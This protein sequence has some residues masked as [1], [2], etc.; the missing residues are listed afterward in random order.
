MERTLDD[1]AVRRICIPEAFLAADACLG[2]LQNVAEGLVV[3]P[4]VIRRR[5]AMN[6]VIVMSAT[7]T[8]PGTPTKKSAS[9]TIGGRSGA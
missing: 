5:T 8:R 1:S 7:S 4:N 9:V 6:D 3:Y 2:I